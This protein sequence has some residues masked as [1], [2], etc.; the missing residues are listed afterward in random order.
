MTR[1][2]TGLIAACVISTVILFLLPSAALG[3]STSLTALGSPVA[4]SPT[5]SLF[6]R[7]GNLLITDQFNNRVIEV[8]PLT[9]QIVWSF[10]SGNSTLCNPG[11]HSIIGPN[12]AERLAGGLTLIAGTGIPAGIAGTTPCVDNRVIVVD[13]VG[14]I[15][16][17]YG[18]AGMMGNGSDLLNV[19]VFATQLPN[20]DFMIVDQG[21]NRVIEVNFQ[22]Q[23]VW[24][25]GPTSGPG[26]LN[27]PNSAELLSNGDILIADEGNNRVIEINHAGQIVWQYVHGLSAPAFA[28]RLPNGN[29]LISDS[30]NARVV[31]ITPA[32]AVV[33]Q[34]FTNRS[35][36][37]NS[38]PAPTNAVRVPGGDIIIADQFNDRVIV[39]DPAKQI[40]FQYGMTNV[41]GARFNELFGPY[42]AYYI[43]SYIGQVPP[44]RY[45]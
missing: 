31:E 25:Y 15:I 37:S 18:R 16:W 40:V 5:H 10:G 9:K 30:G 2:R 36:A 27:S 35:A 29:T 39:I 12:D 11:P 38:T 45:F 6:N 20:H 44:P 8:S 23:V 34:Y 17:Q 42:S 33:F 1:A 26:A 32:K 21:N 19:P 24:C 43:G 13:Q 41:P 7:P 3:G 28:S 4:Q 14:T 22:K